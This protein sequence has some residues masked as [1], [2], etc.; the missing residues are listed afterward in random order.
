MA[1]GERANLENLLRSSWERQIILQAMGMPSRKHKKEK[2]H[3]QRGLDAGWSLAAVMAIALWLAAPK[4]GRLPTAL[5]LLLMTTFL[6]H[7]I[8]KTESLQTG[9]KR[10][11]KLTGAGLVALTFLMIF[12]LWVWP[13]IRRHFLSTKERI[14][15][16]TPL[17]SVGGGDLK[18][19][20]GCPANDERTCIYAGQFISLFGESG[21]SV[22][23]IPSRVTLS[24]A[25]EGIV[26]YRR[27]G[28]KDD[29][30]KR[31][32]SGGYFAINEQHLLAVQSAFRAIHIE[33]DGGTNPDLEEKT[34]MVYVGP[35]REDDSAA[36]GLTSATAWATGKIKGSFPKSQ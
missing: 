22:E 3:V 26:I 15:F 19:Q 35:E 5:G 6:A 33:I 25:S 2:Q 9:S 21:W 31:W 27:G 10:W 17:K 12:G 1:K 18:I 7:A 32:N 29:M 8:W 30:M 34:M 11:A 20:V 4:I 16:E 14:W 36:T 23:P 24:K 28:N 13:P